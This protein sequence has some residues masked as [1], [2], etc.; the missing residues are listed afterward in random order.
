MILENYWET[1]SIYQEWG[2]LL[3][4]FDLQNSWGH[5]PSWAMALSRQPRRQLGHHDDW[6]AAAFASSHWENCG[7]SHGWAAQ[8]LQGPRVEQVKLERA[9]AI[10][11]LPQWSSKTAQ[12]V[13]SVVVFDPS[14]FIAWNGRILWRIAKWLPDVTSTRSLQKRFHKRPWRWRSWKPSQRHG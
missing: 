7:S 4:S 5:F 2:K 1:H 6:G 8:F 12:S 11:F 10:H 13:D 9:I 14:D 3:I